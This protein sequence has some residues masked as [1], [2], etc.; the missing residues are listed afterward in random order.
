MSKIVCRILIGTAIMVCSISMLEADSAES[1]MQMIDSTIC[2]ECKIEG[3]I[4]PHSASTDY[5][6]IEGEIY[7]P[8][9]WL[10]QR[11]G[12]TD[13][14]CNGKNADNKKAN[15]RIELPAYFRQFEANMLRKATETVDITQD[16]ACIF[17]SKCTRKESVKGSELSA[18]NKKTYQSI[19]IEMNI[20]SEGFSITFAIYNYEMVDD[21]FY[22]SEKELT[23]FGIC[24]ITI[25][26]KTKKAVVTYWTQKEVLS[27]SE[28]Y[29]KKV[30]E[31]LRDCDSNEMIA[32]W[33]EAQRTR[34]GA[35][36]YILLSKELQEKVLPEIKERG[37]VTGG[38]SPSLYGGKDTIQDKKEPDD[39]TVIYTVSYQSMLEEEVNET[40]EQTVTIKRVEEEGRSYWRIT[41]VTGDVGYYTYENISQ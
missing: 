26:E 40:L 17:N 20:V 34:N 41:K 11:I 21:C 23:N 13:Y 3:D 27:M 28:Q 24:N 36:Q 2:K 35:L 12:V 39:Q 8:L 16:N 22:I 10:L 4:V 18:V 7:I 33:I 1:G 25:D 31:Q 14:E 15:I 6:L 38:S 30:E 9:E 32:L 19:P 5:R 37:W 29:I